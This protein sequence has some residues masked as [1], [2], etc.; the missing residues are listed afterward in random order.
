[1]GSNNNENESRVLTEWLYK[2]VILATQK[3]IFIFVVLP[4][5]FNFDIYDFVSKLIPHA[6]LTHLVI[7]I[8][9]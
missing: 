8:L 1:M 9:L 4:T 6:M 3:L 5:T 2:I 7:I